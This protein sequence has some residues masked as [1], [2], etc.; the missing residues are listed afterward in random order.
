MK[1]GKFVFGASIVFILPW[2]EQLIVQ[3]L[4]EFIQISKTSIINRFTMDIFNV[5]CTQMTKLEYHKRCEHVITF[6]QVK[7][8]KL[9]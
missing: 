1:R 3:K 6:A 7:T 4:H 5:L 9:S 2:T 8:D